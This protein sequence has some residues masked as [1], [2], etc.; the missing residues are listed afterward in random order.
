MIPL[1]LG[2]TIAN[3]LLMAAVFCMG[4]FVVDHTGQVTSMYAR[5]LVLGLG[6]GLMATLTHV[7]VYM[8]HMATARWLQAATD[9]VGESQARWA[10]P[11]LTRKR[12]VF[13]IMMATIGV[14]MLAMFAGAAADPMVN[15]WWPGEVH[16][17]AGLLALAA[18]GSAAIS[19]Y[20][21]IRRQGEL[22]DDALAELNR[23]RPVQEFKSAGNHEIEASA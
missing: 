17:M 2:L 1:F 21:H 12:K 10:A 22:M 9:K 16:M 13:F 20:R 5:H 23:P 18:N 11:A 4:L 14:T 8:Y 15:P 7:A 19:E 6:T 3:L